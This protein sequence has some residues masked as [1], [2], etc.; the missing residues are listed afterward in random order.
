MFAD[1]ALVCQSRPE[2]SAQ[3]EAQPRLMLIQSCGA[4]GVFFHAFGQSF[5]KDGARAASVDFHRRICACEVE[6]VRT[7][8]R[9]VDR[10]GTA[11][12][13]YELSVSV[14]GIRGNEQPFVS[15]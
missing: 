11:G 13:S 10:E 15:S 2:F 8:P 9:S 14:V 3:G 1:G 7:T 5:T 6:G 4:V 12:K